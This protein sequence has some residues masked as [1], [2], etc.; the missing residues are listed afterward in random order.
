MGKRLQLLTNRKLKDYVKDLI[1]NGQE[2]L[3]FKKTAK[4]KA[5]Q[6]RPEDEGKEI[7]TIMKNGLKETK[8]IIEKDVEGNYCWIATN[9]SGEQY[10]IPHATFIQKYEVKKGADGKHAP[11]GV[12]IKVIQINDDIEFNAPWGEKMQIKAGGYLNID[13]EEKIYGI[14][15]EEFEETYSKCD[16]NGVLVCSEKI[17]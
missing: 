6:A 2:P 14:Q 1:K 10:I 12:P 15:K 13:N 16:K 11:I 17:F 3:F 8:N 5:E 4:I 9:P 7:V